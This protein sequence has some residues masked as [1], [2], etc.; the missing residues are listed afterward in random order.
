MKTKDNLSSIFSN[1][2]IAQAAKNLNIQDEAATIENKDQDSSKISQ[3]NEIAA[4]VETINKNTTSTSEYPAMEGL[5]EPTF[6]NNPNRTVG[7][8]KG[9]TVAFKNLIK[10]CSFKK[11]AFSN[12]ND[13]I[14]AVMSDPQLSFIDKQQVVQLLQNAPSSLI[15]T[16]RQNIGPLMGA[17]IGVLIAKLLLGA[18]PI[19]M[20]GSAAIGGFLGNG[21]ENMMNSTPIDNNPYS[22]TYNPYRSKGNPF[23]RLY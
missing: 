9:G 6:I 22:D 20:L 3:D 12:A 2:T 5:T 18:G 8:G 14:A 10:Q 16:L 4:N 11:L 15:N 17:G 23:N 13:L 1:T 19:G 7:N 21:I